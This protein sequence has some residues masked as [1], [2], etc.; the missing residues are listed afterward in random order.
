MMVDRETLWKEYAAL[1]D[2]ARRQADEFIARLSSYRTVRRELMP[3]ASEP[4]V[5]MWRDRGDMANNRDW[6]RSLCEREWTRTGD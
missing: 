5:G 2:E 6:V 4:F 3:L 1:P